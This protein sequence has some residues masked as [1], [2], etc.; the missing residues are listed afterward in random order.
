[1][2]LDDSMRFAEKARASGVSI[3]LEV[4]DEMIHIWP[5][6]AAILPEGQQAIERIGRFIKMRAADD[7]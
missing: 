1:V 4:W 5:Y 7:R 6:F 2:L 3:D